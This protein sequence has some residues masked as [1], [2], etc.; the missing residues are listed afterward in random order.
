VDSSLFAVQRPDSTV[1]WPLT[2]GDHTIVCTDQQGR[3]ASVQVL[4]D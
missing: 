4:V 1:F 2:P 3:S